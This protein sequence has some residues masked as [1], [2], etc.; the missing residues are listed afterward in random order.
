MYIFKGI[1][2]LRLYKEGRGNTEYITFVSRHIHI[3][4][5]LLA[6]ESILH[7]NGQHI[8][9]RMKAANEAVIDIAE[10]EAP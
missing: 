8:L 7:K 5:K 6:H 10:V 3:K 9:G 4:R 1:N 2:T